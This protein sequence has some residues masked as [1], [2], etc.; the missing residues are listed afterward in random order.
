MKTILFYWS[1]GADTRRA[2]VRAIASSERS[3]KPCYLNTLAE[4]LELS[5]VAVKKH[6]D[7]LIE[8]KYVKVMNPGGK[9]AFL[10]LTTKGAE[11]AR[12]LSA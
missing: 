4:K 3:Q 9:P 1:R 5:H 8:E 11:I 10:G 2:I 7:L 12:E 6:L